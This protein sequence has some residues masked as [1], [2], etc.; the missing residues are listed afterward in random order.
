MR[1]K[2]FAIALVLSVTSLFAADSP[3]DL[4]GF[5]PDIAADRDM[6]IAPVSSDPFIFSY[7]G[8]I[9]PAIVSE[10]SSQSSVTSSM[11][12]VKIWARMTLG[13]NSFIYARG[14][15]LYTRVLSSYAGK[16]STNTL[17][18]DT[19]YIE[20]SFMERS[21]VVDAGR[22]F[23]TVGSG[24]VLNDRGD[25][26]NLSFNN[27]YVNFSLFGMYTGLLRKEDN[28]YN[29][30][31]TDT[32]D[33]AKRI[34]AGVI[35]DK[36][37]LNQTAY[38]FFADQI[39]R[40]KQSAGEKTRYQSMYYGAGL[41]GVPLDG[42]DYRVEG[43][44]EMGY[45]YTGTA[46]LE[47]KQVSAFAGYALLNYYFDA[48]LKPSMDLNYVY[49]SGDKDRANT[50]SSG[51]TK[52]ND[53][54]FI[55]FGG[56]PL[57]IA[58]RPSLSNMHIIRAGASFKPTMWMSSERFNRMFLGAKYSYYLKDK[59]KGKVSDS[60]TANDDRNLGQALDLNYR[61]E[62]FR[63]LSI[64]TQYGIFFPG[65]A[66]SSSEKARQLVMAGT[67]IEF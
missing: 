49:A 28:P 40:A 34:F 23:F 65:K 32:T 24:I 5:I 53:N 16:K 22:R 11:N 7:G 14:K 8:W 21:F 39:D 18:L 50:G 43:I 29:L 27:R 54:G 37:F 12:S 1:S 3:D 19:G 59:P 2:I 67:L 58:Y 38:F 61:W 51:N 6:A 63:D 33:G 48:F 13:G 25:G 4:F 36:S 26:M 20:G 47:K 35:L 46:A 41:K 55:G 56:I 62:I 45:S 44:Y 64:F 52:S 57:G 60:A 42:M 31:I 10:D 30:S 17:D 66:Y 15:D 9:V